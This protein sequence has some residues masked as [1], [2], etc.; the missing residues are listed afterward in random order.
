MTAAGNGGQGRRSAVAASRALIWNRHG[1]SADSSSHTTSVQ[2]ASGAIRT[3]WLALAAVSVLLLNIELVAKGR[4]ATVM[5]QGYGEEGHIRQALHP[6]TRFAGNYP[7]IGA[8]MVD[9]EP[10]GIGIREDRSR[11]T[12]NLSR[13]IPHVIV[14]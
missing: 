9:A 7:I 8:W 12:K 4:R 3:A 14:G 5:D 13:F 6:I 1:S 11:V 2:E 10:A